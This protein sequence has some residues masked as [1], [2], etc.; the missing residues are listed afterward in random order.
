MNGSPGLSRDP[1][2]AVQ[3]RSPSAVERIVAAG[4]TRPDAL[5][6]LE[7]ADGDVELALLA[8]LAKNIVVPT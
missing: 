7:R 2:R 5:V 8:L 1:E 4:F 6:A 3:E